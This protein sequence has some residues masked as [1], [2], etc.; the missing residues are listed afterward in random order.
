MLTPSFL[1]AAS[2]ILA[3]LS[4]TFF[5]LLPSP[6]CLLSISTSYEDRGLLLRSIVVTNVFEVHFLI[7]SKASLLFRF[8]SV[9]STSFT[10]LFRTRLLMSTLLIT[11]LLFFLLRSISEEVMLSSI[12]WMVDSL[13]VYGF[14]RVSLSLMGFS[15]SSSFSPRE[16]LSVF[17]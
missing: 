5:K 6:L 3:P 8:K 15:S 4:T 11:F 10:L 1:R 9:I 16:G 12:E 14:L 13:S 17:H 7:A 2:L